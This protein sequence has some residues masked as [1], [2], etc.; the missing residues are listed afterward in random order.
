MS[1]LLYKE[2]VVWALQK[3]K[4]KATAGKA[5]IPAKMMNREVLVEL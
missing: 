3:L 4:V 2:E 5:G 1:A